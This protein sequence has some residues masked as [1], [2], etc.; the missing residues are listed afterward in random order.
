VDR[1]TSAPIQG[2]F[3]Q[4]VDGAGKVQAGV[5]SD[6]EGRFIL[7]V[8]TP[9]RY[10]LRSERI[11]YANS[12]SDTIMVA[13]GET[14]SYRF[15]VGV[16]AVSLEGLTVTAAKGRCRL[17]QQAGTAT[18][19]IW[20]AARKALDVVVWLEKQRGVP[21]QDVLWDRT[22][23]L[24]SG[25]LEKG[26]R[27]ISSGFGKK[28]FRSASGED[29][30]QSGFVRWS[31]GPTYVYYGL[32]AQALLSN[33]FLN[34]HCFHVVEPHGHEDQGLVGLSFKPVNANGPPDIDGTL[35]LD[36]KTS[37][38]RY[39]EFEYTRHLF[40][41]E[42]VPNSRFGGRVDF[43]RLANG[44]WVVRKWWLRMP[45]WGKPLAHPFPGA[46]TPFR[47]PL[48][49]ARA[50]GLRIREKGGEIR[51]MPKLAASTDTGTATVAGVVYDSVDDRPLAG[52]TVFLADDYTTA[53]KTDML[54]G[55]RLEGVPAGKH[56]LGFFSPLT[57]S[58]DLPVLTDSVLVPQHGRTKVTLAVPASD[59]CRPTSASTTIVGFVESVANGAPL[60][61]VRVQAEWQVAGG[62]I[63][64]RGRASSDD[65]GRYRLCGVPVGET[66]DLSVP[67]GPKSTLYVYSVRPIR[68]DLLADRR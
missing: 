2:A 29:L 24:I 22:E 26:D 34:G 53:A 68:K 59:G 8:P 9:G 25:Q 48:Q 13:A 62:S 21:F 42:G 54:G 60:A 66:V 47:P 35:W 31:P 67:H 65:R 43:H 51:F 14:L 45:L 27:R 12:V 17:S 64:M 44:A 38:L 56:V 61:G 50:D 40:S 49:Q 19:T 63:T 15:A 58:L 57:D 37:E 11:G 3:V 4:L 46:I 55:F 39:L 20:D 36:R 32:D 6:A 10:T 30:E 5:L 28:A 7:E 52:A 1:A 18:S 33:A 23:D 16:H 41:V